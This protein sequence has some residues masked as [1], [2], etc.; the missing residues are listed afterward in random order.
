MSQGGLLLI[1]IGVLAIVIFIA[2]IRP[3]RRSAPVD[4]VKSAMAI[5]RGLAERDGKQSPAVLVHQARAA[6]AAGRPMVALDAARWA[7]D[8]ND[9]FVNS[10]PPMTGRVPLRPMVYHP[11]IYETMLDALNR[12]RTDRFLNADQAGKVALSEW[13]ASDNDLHK[14]HSSG[15]DTFWRLYLSDYLQLCALAY[16]SLPATGAPNLTRNV[17]LAVLQYADEVP[18]GGFTMPGVLAYQ[19]LQRAVGREGTPA[20]PPAR[21]RPRDYDRLPCGSLI[22]QAEIDRWASTDRVSYQPGS[23]VTVP[24]YS[25]SRIRFPRPATTNMEELYKLSLRQIG[26]A[27]SVPDAW[28]AAVDIAIYRWELLPS[29][30]EQSTNW[31]ESVVTDTWAVMQSA[32]PTDGPLW[33]WENLADLFEY[34]YERVVALI[35]TIDRARPLDLIHAQGHENLFASFLDRTF[36]E[37]GDAQRRYAF[38]NRLYTT[39]CRNHHLG[40]NA[41][42]IARLRMLEQKF[43]PCP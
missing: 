33:T 26:V 42:M 5:T 12:C 3:W 17:V 15:D 16:A 34:C 31:V 14:V 6:L 8:R 1:I 25:T 20:T 21:E 13:Q 35:P 2:V 43:G 7:R 9:D 38:E 24:E 39:L 37:A 27:Q 32:T 29:Y 10:L 11:A 4:P 41:G 28:W 40:L 23:A 30:D 19:S 36:R 18:A 22:D